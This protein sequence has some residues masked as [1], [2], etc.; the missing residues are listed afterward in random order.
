MHYW[1][2]GGDGLNSRISQNHTPDCR[3]VHSSGVI[4]AM[5][6][7]TRVLQLPLITMRIVDD[8]WGVVA[9]IEVFEH[10]G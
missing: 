2:E 9:F 10:A 3:V 5:V 8:P 6:V 4:L 1:E 7:D